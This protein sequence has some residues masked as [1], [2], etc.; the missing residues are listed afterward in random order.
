MTN[1]DLLF[2]LGVHWF[3]RAGWRQRQGTPMGRRVSAAS[4]TDLCA[5]RARWPSQ[6]RWLPSTSTAPVKG[7]E[8]ARCEVE[9]YASGVRSR[10]RR[11]TRFFLRGSSVL[12]TPRTAQRAI[13][14]NR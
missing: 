9:L 1:D 11:D 6:V 2:R 12:G 7:A 5:A 4:A 14:G 3:T 10:T 8:P 13:C